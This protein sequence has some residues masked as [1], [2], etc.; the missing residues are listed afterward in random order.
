MSSSFSVPEFRKK[1]AG[2]QEVR[3]NA[4]KSIRPIYFVFFFSFLLV[5]VLT[6]PRHVYGILSEQQ[7]IN[8][9][10]QIDESARSTLFQSAGYDEIVEMGKINHCKEANKQNNQI[11]V[12][13]KRVKRV[14]FII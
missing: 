3:K 6:V 11:H 13:I 7:R 12:S 8:V 9:R 10:K 1:S 4:S 14:P 5:Q 2:R